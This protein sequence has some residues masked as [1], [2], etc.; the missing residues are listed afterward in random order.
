MAA[1]AA[2]VPPKLL[3]HCWLT[4]ALAGGFTIAE[5]RRLCFWRWLARRRGEA[6]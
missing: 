4:E 6:R 3:L 1:P 2:P 5:A